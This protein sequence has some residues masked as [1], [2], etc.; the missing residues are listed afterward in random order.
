MGLEVT[1]ILARANGSFQSRKMKKSTLGTSSKTSQYRTLAD[2]QRSQL[3]GKAL[4]HPSPSA[5]RHA[6]AHPPAHTG[7]THSHTASRPSRATAASPGGANIL[8]EQQQTAMWHADV[9]RH[10]R[11]RGCAPV[12]PK[13]LLQG[14]HPASSWPCGSE[15]PSVS[16]AGA[17]WPRVSG[18]R[19][20]VEPKRAAYSGPADSS[21]TQQG[22]G[23]LWLRVPQH[24]P[25]TGAR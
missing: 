17:A 3:T 10:G 2:G 12:G 6:H 24:N 19:F 23:R 7:E 18:L 9:G 14:V 1:R 22:E 15:S 13:H 11:G 4:S 25:Q 16:S 5:A 21:P 8:I 20:P